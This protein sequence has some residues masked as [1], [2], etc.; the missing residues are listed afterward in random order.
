MLLELLSSF[1]NLEF[2]SSGSS[3]NGPHKHE[4]TSTNAGA[5]AGGAEIEG[6]ENSPRK[7]E[8][9]QGD[10]GPSCSKPQTISLQGAH[11]IPAIIE[12]FL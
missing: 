7:Q 1:S 6:K 11:E 2:C 8:R 3:L 10:P 4:D 5:G 12:C 9:L